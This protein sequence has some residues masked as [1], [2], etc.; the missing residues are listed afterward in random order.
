MNDMV[1][2]LVLWIVVAVAMMTAYQG[3]SGSS[4]GNA[5]I[6]TMFISDVGNN[7]VAATKFNEVAKLRSPKKTVLTY[8]GI[9][10]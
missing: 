2:N 7:Q 9:T 3:F 6:Y 10:Y 5:V 8:N 1:K 4:S